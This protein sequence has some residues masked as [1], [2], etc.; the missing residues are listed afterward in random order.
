MKNVRDAGTDGLTHNQVRLR[1]VCVRGIDKEVQGSPCR[2][3]LVRLG[4]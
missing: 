4:L 3:D 2:L 1:Q